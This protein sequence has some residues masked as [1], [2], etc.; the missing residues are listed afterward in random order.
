M[1]K[2]NNNYY[3]YFCNDLHYLGLQSGHH[4]IDYTLTWQT[5]LIYRAGSTYNTIINQ[6][7]GYDWPLCSQLALRAVNLGSSI[8][9]LP[10]MMAKQKI[11]TCKSTPKGT[12]SQI[13]GL[14]SI[15]ARDQHDTLQDIEILET[16]G[17]Q[18][19]AE[20]GHVS[21]NIK[22][23]WS[24]HFTLYRHIPSFYYFTS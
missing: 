15:T 17:T 20:I 19:C 9:P 11:A 13:I 21:H 5:N 22:Y 2:Y 14:R 3:F 24:V 4:H 1:G 8:R 7:N 23:H 12:L 18:S 6:I 10:P 16:C